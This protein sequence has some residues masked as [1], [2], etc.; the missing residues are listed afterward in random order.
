MWSSKKLTF[1][2]LG[3]LIYRLCPWVD[4]EIFSAFCREERKALQ[5]ALDHST[6]SLCWNNYLMEWVLNAISASARQPEYHP[7]PS[8][9]LLP[10]PPLPKDKLVLAMVMDSDISLVSAYLA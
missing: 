9:N 2:R 3:V 8:S 6:S 4:S 1:I 7:P 10:V 5:L